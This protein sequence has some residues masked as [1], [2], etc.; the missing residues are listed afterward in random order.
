[1]P[2]VTSTVLAV[3]CVRSV[4]E[5]LDVVV[6]R[7]A[8]DVDT[9]FTLRAR[10]GEGKQDQAMD[11]KRAVAALLRV[12]ERNREVVLVLPGNNKRKN[13]ALSTT[14]ASHLPVGRGVLNPSV[15]RTNSPACARFV[16][17]LEAGNGFP[18]L[19]HR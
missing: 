2:A 8:V 7:I 9:F 1:M 19:S 3:L 10:A 15:E 14:A 13:L 12:T 11:E 17:A 18:N 5:V 6:H 4:T 16:A